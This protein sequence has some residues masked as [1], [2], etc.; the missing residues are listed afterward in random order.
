MH[1]R[2][3]TGKHVQSETVSCASKCIFFFHY[4]HLQSRRTKG[5]PCQIV[6]DTSMCRRHIAFRHSN[7]YRQWCKTNNFELMLPQDIKE[8]KTVVAIANVQQT[9]LDGHLQ[10]KPSTDIVVPYTNTIFREA[11]IGWLISTSQ[12]IQAI[13][14]LAFQ[15][16]IAVAAHAMS[17]VVLPNRNATRGE[18]MNLFKKQMTKLKECLNVSFRS[19]YFKLMFC[20]DVANRASSCLALST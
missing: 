19:Y 8:R 14:H 17:G 20:T 18:I 5:Y 12:P 13:D 7:N 10:E 16:M 11:A 3:R 2:P 1:T 4:L 15:K 9:S 6:S